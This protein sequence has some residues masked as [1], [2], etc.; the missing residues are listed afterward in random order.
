MHIQFHSPAVYWV[1]ALPVGNGRLGAMVFGGIEKER[2]ALNEDTLWSGYPRDWNNPGVLYT[3]ADFDRAK[4][5]AA[6]G[7]I[8]R[9]DAWYAGKNTSFT[10]PSYTPRPVANPYR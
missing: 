10:S 5:K 8:P 3:Q 7:A 1:E 6:M 2:V 4:Q 9:I